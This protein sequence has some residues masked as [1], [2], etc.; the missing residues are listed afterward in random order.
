MKNVF[1]AIGSLFFG[2]GVP[3]VLDFHN[4]GES[5]IRVLQDSLRAM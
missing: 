4:K 5:L 3:S 2:L 1:E